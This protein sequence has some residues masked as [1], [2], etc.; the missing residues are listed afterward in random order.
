MTE[1]RGSSQVRRRVRWARF[2]LL[3][4]PVIVWMVLIFLLSAQTQ[5]PTPESRILDVFFEK[6]AHT[7]EYAILAALLVRALSP[8][9]EEKWRVFATAVLVAG[10][11]ALTDELHQ[12]YVPGR[13]ADWADVVF[14]WM[15]AGIGAALVLYCG[16]IGKAFGRLWQRWR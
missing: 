2:L 10:A 16:R 6:T 1:W 7:V 12:K 9:H 4:S 3:W 14:D 5:Y 11:Y 8:D 15:G 13:S